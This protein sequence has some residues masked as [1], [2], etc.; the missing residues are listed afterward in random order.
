MKKSLRVILAV[1]MILG[2]IIPAIT[3]DAYGPNFDPVYYANKYPDV[4]QVF[5][6]TDPEVLYK[7]Y[8]DYGIKEGRFQN[9]N[10]E[11]A[12]KGLLT[13]ILDE[14]VVPVEGYETYTY[15]D[16]DIEKQLVTYFKKGQIEFQCYCVSGCVNTKHDTP[17]GVFWIRCKVPGKRL[18][19]PTWD[20]WV[21]RWMRFT[22]TACGFHDATW[23]G[24]FGGEIYKNNGSHGCV[25][26]SKEAA[27]TLYDY[28][29]VGT[30]VIV[31]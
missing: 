16:V 6:T 13:G 29:K 27:Y 23:R 17:K 2:C 30:I 3:A 4:V 28:V 19:G 15:V 20:C 7:H 18:K 31:H 11:N 9:V 22:D 24:S 8:L 12:A 1:I 14:S 26:L 5:G 10:E 21:N 25:N